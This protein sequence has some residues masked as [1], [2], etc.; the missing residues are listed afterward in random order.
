MKCCPTIAMSSLVPLRAS[1]S[2]WSTYLGKSTIVE[3]LPLTSCDVTNGLQRKRGFATRPVV[4]EFG[5]RPADGGPAGPLLPL[6]MLPLFDPF[7]PP[8]L[9]EPWGNG[10]GGC[11]PGRLNLLSMS[12]STKLCA[13]FA[14]IREFESSK[15]REVEPSA[16]L[17]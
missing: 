13:R 1:H 5:R 16:I 8:P 11:F 6:G 2:P 9:P 17:K 4:G 3:K 7:D 12:Q 14:E 10:D 15:V